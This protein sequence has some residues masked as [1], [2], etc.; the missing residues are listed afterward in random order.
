MNNPMIQ[1]S[2]ERTNIPNTELENVSITKLSVIPLLNGYLTVETVYSDFYG[3]IFQDY[4]VEDWYADG[5]MENIKNWLDTLELTSEKRSKLKKSR[6][7]SLINVHVTYKYR[8]DNGEKQT[9]RVIYTNE[10]PKEIKEYIEIKFE[11]LL[12][13]DNITNTV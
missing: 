10:C 11:T 9:F 1:L 12:H 6:E 2:F 4:V 3:A 13:R 7:D 5:V 8:M